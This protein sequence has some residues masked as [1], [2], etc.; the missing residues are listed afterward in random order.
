[1]DDGGQLSAAKDF[2][3][4]KPSPLSLSI[5][6]APSFSVSFVRVIDD[7][8]LLLLCFVVGL[9]IGR[10]LPILSLAEFSAGS[11][12]RNG[13]KISKINQVSIKMKLGVLPGIK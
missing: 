2:A 11:R 4:V 8:E 3:K 12:G 7:E 5:E 6:T 10:S 9:G 13:A 1:M